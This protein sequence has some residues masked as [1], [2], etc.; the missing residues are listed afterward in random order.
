MFFIL[1]N[2]TSDM[3]ATYLYVLKLWVSEHW[4]K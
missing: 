2:Y 1:V 4:F 3:H